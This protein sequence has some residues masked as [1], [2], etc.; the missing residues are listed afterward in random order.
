MI[1]DNSNDKSNSITSKYPNEKSTP[2]Y[3]L[4]PE[5]KKPFQV[6]IEL[7]IREAQVNKFFREFWKLKNLN[8]LYDIYPQIIQSLPLSKGNRT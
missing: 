5:G 1:T 3:K 2:A 4:F 7:G 6:A 8:E